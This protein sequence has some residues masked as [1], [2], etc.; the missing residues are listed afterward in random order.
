MHHP[1]VLFDGECNLC[2]GSVRFIIAHDPAGVF[3]FAATQSPSGTALLTD[4]GIDP[5]T[6]DGVVVVDGAQVFTGADAA[7]RVARSLTGW[8]RLLGVLR[9]VPRWLR[10]ALYAM[11][12]RNRYRWFGRRS[13]CLVPTPALRARFLDQ[14]EA[15]S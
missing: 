15:I 11:V 5:A 10:D 9:V 4:H 7:L 12:A 13:L 6:L 3:R 2:D 1:V 8:W 14:P